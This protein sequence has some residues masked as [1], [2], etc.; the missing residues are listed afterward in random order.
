M[1]NSWANIYRL[2]IKEL[3]SLLRDPA[4]LV[5][6]AYTFTLSIYVAAT[7]MPESLHHAAIAIVDNDGSPLSA[8]IAATFY[9]PHF[10]VAR[11]VTAQEADAGLDD[12]DYTFVLDIPADF[13]RDVLAGRAPAVQLNVD[14]T[15]MSQ[16]FTG[17]S[18]IQQMITTEVMQFV[19]RAEGGATAPVNLAMRM[20]F[21]PNLEQS[22]F[23]SLM[24]IINNVTMLSIILTGAAL[25]REREHGTIEHLLVM[26]VTPAE[27]MLAKVWSMGLVVAL[28]ALASLMLIVRGA[29][30]V[31]IEGSVALFML[32][33]VMHL[34]ATTSMGIFM[35]TLARSMPQ[36]GMLTVLV[37]LPLQL[38]S[39]GSTPRES[40][41]LLVQDIMLAAPTTHFVAAGQ[42]I[43]YRGAGLEVV[44]P[45]LL[46]IF[47]IGALLFT[48]ALG[49]FRKTISQM[50]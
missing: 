28:A 35:A 5:L 20:R 30:Q 34:F 46:A 3:W 2:G 42:A 13:Q 37:L 38:L 18:Y 40:M 24:E 47:A 12:G 23:G 36:F 39:G 1:R 29:L 10:K 43:L 32:A 22:W 4:M 7:A 49:R 6:I 41:P 26:P 27:I 8:R 19:Q 16:A 25:I 17:N 14:A 31:P 15:R 11:L 50:A 44:W 33:T 45:Q 21:N 48:A 9:P